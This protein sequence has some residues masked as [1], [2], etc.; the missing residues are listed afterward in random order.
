M[1]KRLIIAMSL[2]T[3]AMMAIVGFSL[4]NLEFRYVAG[5]E[6]YSLPVGA[7]GELLIGA[8]ALLIIVVMGLTLYKKLKSVLWRQWSAR[9]KHMPAQD[10]P[11]GDS[12]NKADISGW[13]PGY[14]TS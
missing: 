12:D 8:A 11:A 5:G 13:L 4:L 9:Q 7:P 6:D 3:V 10:A 14:F 2:L 1:E